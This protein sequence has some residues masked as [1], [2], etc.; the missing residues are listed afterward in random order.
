M[1][2]T[3]RMGKGEHSMIAELEQLIREV[4][5]KYRVEGRARYAGALVVDGAIDVPSDPASGYWRVG[6]ETVNIAHGSCTCL[7]DDAPRVARGTMAPARLCG[8]MLAAMFV[9]RLY[10][11]NGL[12][13]MAILQAGHDAGAEF[14]LRVNVLFGASEV[15][16]VT[17]YQMPGAPWVDLAAPGIRL[18]PRA[19]SGLCRLAGVDMAGPRNRTHKGSIAFIYPMIA[20]ARP[21]NLAQAHGLAA[22]DLERRALN[23]R[24]TIID[25]QHSTQPYYAPVAT[26]PAPSRG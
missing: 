6:D 3:E 18:D 7:D 5:G 25:L 17:A 21:V 15:W 16:T 1:D 23:T 20:T 12:A 13:L 14:K 11:A 8:H 22:M 26:A 24:L 9:R 19:F 2:P 10:E 4:E